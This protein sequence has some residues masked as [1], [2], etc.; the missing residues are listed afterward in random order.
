MAH[1]ARLPHDQ[2]KA[3]FF[4]VAHVREASLLQ[5]SSQAGTLHGLFWFYVYELVRAICDFMVL[6]NQ[7]LQSHAMQLSL[8]ELRS[9]CLMDH[10]VHT[11]VCLPSM[12]FFFLVVVVGRTTLPS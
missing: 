8:L 5:F 10:D 2:P 4:G 9:G 3:V 11:R 12:T 1:A 7:L 6:H